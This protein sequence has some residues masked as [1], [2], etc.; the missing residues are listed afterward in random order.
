[1][2]FPSLIKANI[3]N[4]F[5]LFKNLHITFLSKHYNYKI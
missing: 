1:M 5:E 4:I 2:F 3:L